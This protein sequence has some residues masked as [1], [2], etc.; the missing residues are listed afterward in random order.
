MS[1]NPFE[2]P[3]PRCGDYVVIRAS[4]TPEQR[5]DAEQLLARNGCKGV[6]FEVLDDGRLQAHGYLRAQ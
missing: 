6:R 1:L 3:A 4:D 2:S 5:L